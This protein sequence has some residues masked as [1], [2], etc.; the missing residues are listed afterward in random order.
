MLYCQG[1]FPDV[2][3]P[4]FWNGPFPALPPPGLQQS[5]FTCPA[6][7]QFEHFFILYQQSFSVCPDF[8]HTEH[9][10]PLPILSDNLRFFG[11]SLAANTFSDS[12]TVPCSSSSSSSGSSFLRRSSSNKIAWSSYDVR[13]LALAPGCVYIVRNCSQERGKDSSANHWFWLQGFD[14]HH[15]ATKSH[16]MSQMCPSVS[17]CIP[18]HTVCTVHHSA[19]RVPGHYRVLQRHRAHRPPVWQ[20]DRC[21]RALLVFILQLESPAFTAQSAIRHIKIPLQ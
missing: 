6:L 4:R 11:P 16:N 5:S 15:R 19:H 3:D 2:D 14:S 9:F 20:P 21:Y 12:R 17:Q 10:L 1:L 8:L 13:L 18:V 7:E